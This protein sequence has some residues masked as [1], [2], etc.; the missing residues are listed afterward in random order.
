MTTPSLE[1]R[2]REALTKLRDGWRSPELYDAV[3]AALAEGDRLREA[4]VIAEA[5]VAATC[6]GLCHVTDEVANNARADLAKVQ[7]ALETRHG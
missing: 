6:G 7:K 3:S 4:L 2:A 1:D 5:Y